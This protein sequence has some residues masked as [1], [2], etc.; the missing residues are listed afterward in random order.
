M[1]TAKEK[2]ADKQI[3]EALDF[4]SEQGYNIPKRG[5]KT[6]TDIKREIKAS[7]ATLEK[8]NYKV[9]G[10]NEYTCTDCGKSLSIKENNFYMSQ[11]R[12]YSGV[13]LISVCKKCLER[14]FNDYMIVNN[15]DVKLSFYMLCREVNA[16]FALSAVDMAIS[17]KNSTFK[18]YFQKINSLKQ[19]QGM[20]F[21]DSDPF[22]STTAEVKEQREVESGK[23]KLSK[24]ERQAKKEVVEAIGRDP[25]VDL[26]VSDQ[27][28]LYPEL[29]EH[30]DEDVQEN[31]FLV[32]QIVQVVL[33]NNTISKLNQMLSRLA[34][35]VTEAH[36]NDDKIRN[37]IN[38][39]KNLSSATTSI[40]KENGIA[41]KGGEGKKRSTLTGMMLYYRDLDL[42]EI[43]VDYYD[44][45]GSIGMERVQKMSMKAIFDQ[46]LFND[47]DLQ[48]MLSHSRKLVE[49]LEKE[50]NKLEEENRKL[51]VILT[52]NKIDYKVGDVD[53]STS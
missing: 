51:K 45:V 17:S 5:R 39:I 27:K 35:D 36:K 13:G 16:V 46:G 41:K 22:D 52:N 1:A 29:L 50:K 32:S 40:A 28:L 34:T 49:S 30:I 23:L 21:K 8:Y 48:E 3:A 38:N 33:N 10:E 2:Q 18:T 42:D 4:L 7:K 53:A 12:M 19:Y 31:P 25:F 24:E 37:L 14:Y 11:S 15:G 9:Q 20:S 26:P 6:A 43:E 44:Q 47:N